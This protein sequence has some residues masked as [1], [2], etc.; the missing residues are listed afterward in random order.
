[1]DL[2]RIGSGRGKAANAAALKRAKSVNRNLETSDKLQHLETFYRP[3][4]NLF[5]SDGNKIV[6]LGEFAENARLAFKNPIDAADTI[7]NFWPDG[8][9]G[10]KAV[11]MNADGWVKSWSKYCKNHGVEKCQEFIFKMLVSANEAMDKKSNDAKLDDKITELNTKTTKPDRELSLEVS[12]LNPLVLELWNSLNF[13]GESDDLLDQ[14]EILFL[15]GDNFRSIFED[16]DTNGDGCIDKEEWMEF[17]ETRLKGCGESH[18]TAE[19]QLAIFYAKRAGARFTEA[20]K[21]CI[22]DGFEEALKQVH[23]EDQKAQQA[24]IC[25]ASVAAALGAVTI[26]AVMWM[27]RK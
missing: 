9:D 5:D 13:L 10:Q 7:L 23:A 24:V 18:T 1:M 19:L 6:E 8:E 21:H 22:G 12:K 26:G 11:S 25:Y 16:L 2:M 4:F 20:K 3:L 14:G 15:Q 27:T 17:W